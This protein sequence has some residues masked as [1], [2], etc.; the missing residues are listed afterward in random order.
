MQ[1]VT[2]VER[3]GFERGLQQGLQTARHMILEVRETRFG[4]VPEDITAAVQH[5][6]TEEDLHALQRQAVLCSALEE[7]REALRTLPSD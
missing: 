3:I 7:L 4:T 5:L 6:E 1:Y 2:S